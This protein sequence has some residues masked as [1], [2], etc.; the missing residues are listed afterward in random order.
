MASVYAQISALPTLAFGG[1]FESLPQ[2]VL[3]SDEVSTS[4]NSGD[5]EII[6]Q[7]VIQSLNLTFLKR[8]IIS[9]HKDDL[10]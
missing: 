7:R 9:F 3:Q 10:D 4:A 6:F 2:E 5:Y 1:G 8:N